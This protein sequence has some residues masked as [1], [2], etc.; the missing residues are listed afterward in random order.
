VNGVRLTTAI[1]AVKWPAKVGKYLLMERK[2]H[3]H[4]D[5]AW[6]TPHNYADPLEANPAAGVS[7]ED[8]DQQIQRRRA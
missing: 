2:W 4:R 8:L 1:S 6:A 7:L 5:I 3:N